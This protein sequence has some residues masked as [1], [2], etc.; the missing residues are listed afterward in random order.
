MTNEFASKEAIH[1]HLGETQTH[2]SGTGF[3]VPER[4][5]SFQPL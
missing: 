4:G 2:R 5:E 3:S 1:Q